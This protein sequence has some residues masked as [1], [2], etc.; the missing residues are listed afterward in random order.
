[1]IVRC[2]FEKHEPVRNVT[3]LAVMWY[4]CN[5]LSSCRTD[6]MIGM[7]ECHAAPRP[8]E[9]GIL[10]SLEEADEVA[11]FTFIDRARTDPSAVKSFVDRACAVFV[12][13]NTDGQLVNEVLAEVVRSVFSTG[14]SRTSGPEWDLD[15]FCE[16]LLLRPEGG[17]ER[18]RMH[19]EYGRLFDC[20][21][22]SDAICS[23][24]NIPESSSA[25]T[26]AECIGMDLLGVYVGA[27]FHG[28]D[29]CGD[30]FVF[31]SCH[32]TP[33]A[34]MPYLLL[35]Q[36]SAECLRAL[37]IVNRTNV[38]ARRYGWRRRWLPLPL[39]EPLPYPEWRAWCADPTKPDAG[40]ESMKARGL[41]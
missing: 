35:A 29:D 14:W 33:P 20:R 40:Y 22:L 23:F 1:M 31:V 32:L 12:V 39:L 25:C 4:C 2:E 11:V 36:L 15:R 24:I 5:F 7:G 13:Q 28:T 9:D 26:F 17:G 41:L 18:V 21:R 37:R 8:G 27:V 30:G 3:A 10:W 34:E 19:P 6:G 16:R 38:L